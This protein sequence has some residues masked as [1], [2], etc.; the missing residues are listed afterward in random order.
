MASN[1]PYWKDK[2][3]AGTNNDYYHYCS[4]E[5]LNYDN[6]T[7]YKMIRI[8]LAGGTMADMIEGSEISEGK[9]S[10]IQGSY[11]RFTDKEIIRITRKKKWWQF[12][13]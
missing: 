13:K 5:S 11:R 10:T 1:C 7:V 4:L 12:W 6:C 9:Y 3:C 2:K 8:K